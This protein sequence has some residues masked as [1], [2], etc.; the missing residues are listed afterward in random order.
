MNTW[1]IGEK[2]KYIYTHTW[3][4]MC[5][6]MLNSLLMKGKV[7]HLSFHFSPVMLAEIK[8]NDFHFKRCL[9]QKQ[10]SLENVT[11]KDFFLF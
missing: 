4:Q 1:A 6:E 8:S 9:C 3:G 11:L 5:G 2:D 10:S 7:F